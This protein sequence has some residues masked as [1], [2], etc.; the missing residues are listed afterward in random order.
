MQQINRLS[1]CIYF[2][3]LLTLQHLIYNKSH[4]FPLL[5]R[6]KT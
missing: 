2:Y 3:V 6:A 4:A 5:D 1:S